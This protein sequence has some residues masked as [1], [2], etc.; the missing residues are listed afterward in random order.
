MPS[1]VTPRRFPPPW[2]V[3]ESDASFI[4]RD[5]TG[6]ALAQKRSPAAALRATEPCGLLASLTRAS[7]SLTM[8]WT[9]FGRASPVRRCRFHVD[10]RMRLSMRSRCRWL[11]RSVP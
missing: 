2:S 9:R 7:P 6:Q 8:R 11:V 10:A 3:G 1:A 5:K 4:V